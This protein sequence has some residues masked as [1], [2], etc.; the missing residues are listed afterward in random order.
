VKPSDVAAAEAPVFERSIAAEW[1]AAARPAFAQIERC[2]VES[3]RLAA[4]RDALLPRLVSGRIRVPLT[5]EPEAALDTVL[6]VAAETSMRV[7]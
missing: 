5:Q 3:R 1:L 7:A 6:D 2:R 4:I